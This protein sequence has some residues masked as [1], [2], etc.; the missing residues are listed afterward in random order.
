MYI[1]GTRRGLE[2][3]KTVAGL[4]SGSGLEYKEIITEKRNHARDLIQNLDLDLYSGVVTVSGD[5]LIHEV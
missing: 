3:W 5:G 2:K 1:V 4:V